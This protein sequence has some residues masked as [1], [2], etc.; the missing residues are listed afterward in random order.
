[1]TGVL[2]RRENS[3]TESHKEKVAQEDSGRHHGSVLPKKRE[4]ARGNGGGRVSSLPRERVHNNP[5][6][7]DA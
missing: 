2:V 3:E 6:T 1:M 7:S 5:G 4:A